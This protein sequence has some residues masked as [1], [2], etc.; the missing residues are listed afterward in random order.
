MRTVLC[1]GND[2]SVRKPVVANRPR[3]KRNV[4]I[5]HYTI[6][7]PV[8]EWLLCK[9][10]ETDRKRRHFSTFEKANTI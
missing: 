3:Y 10:D 4:I 5:K 1:R 9:S 6:V 2:A 7:R 8:K